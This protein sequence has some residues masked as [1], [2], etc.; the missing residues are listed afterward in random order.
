LNGDPAMNRRSTVEQCDVGQ[1]GCVE[2]KNL[3]GKC[4]L[5]SDEA[6]R[7]MRGDRDGVDREEIAPHGKHDCQRCVASLTRS[8]GGQSRKIKRSH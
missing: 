4:V 2:I 6:F 8:G 5:M 7:A 3:D 1:E